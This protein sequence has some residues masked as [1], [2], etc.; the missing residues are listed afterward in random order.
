MTDYVRRFDPAARLFI[1]HRLDKDTSG[2]LLFA[3]TEAAKRALQDDWNS[4]VQKREYIAV[5]EGCP[6]E[7]SGVIRS[8]LN[9]SKTHRVYSG[10]AETGRLAVTHY[11]VLRSGGGYSLLR[12]NIETGRKNQIRA[13]LK[14]LGCPV[15]G[16]KKYGARTNPLKRLGLHASALELVNPLTK[17]VLALRSPVPPSFERL[18]KSK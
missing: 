2:V 18:L 12:V 17:R 16:D 3:K 10:R 7:K 8:Y 6:E 1:V 9:E 5:V 13:H 11:A 4:L 14:E 15:A